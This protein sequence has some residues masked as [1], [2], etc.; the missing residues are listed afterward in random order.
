[1]RIRQALDSVQTNVMMADASN[2]VIYMNQAV[3]DMLRNA[4]TDI[5]EKLK[6]FDVDKILGGSIDVFH[7]NPAHQRSMLQAMNAVHEVDIKIGRRT[8]HLI[9]TPIYDNDK[10]RLGTAVE[11]QDMTDQLEREA[12]EAARLEEE[13]KVA[14]T[15]DRIRQALDSATGNMMIADA[16]FNI[17]YMNGAVEGM[18]RNAAND[19]RKELPH[20]D[21]N[22]LI[23][24]NMDIFHKDPSHQRSMMGNA[25]QPMIGNIK[26][27][28]RTMRVIGSPIK[29]ADTGERLGYAVEW[30]DRTQE[31]AI[32]QE[33]D[34][35]VQAAKAG[36]LTNRIETNDKEGFFKSLSAGVNELVDVADEVIQATSDV[37]GSLSRGDLS[38]KIRGDFQGTFG[39]LR[40]DV[41]NT[42]DML[43]QVMG[44]TGDAL[45]AMARGDLTHAI[46]GSYE[47]I[48]AQIVEDT[49]STVS[50]LTQVLD[51]INA[52]SA[53]VLHGAQEISEG[54]TNLSQRTEEQAA[55]LEETASS[56]EQMTSTVKA[57]AENAKRADELAAGA[58]E[59]ALR[60]GSVVEH[61]ITAMNAI[62]DSSRKIADIISVIDE[63]AFQTNLLALNAAVE[64]A[65]A[66]EQGR[67]FAVV[68]TEVR[69]LA[70][71]S[72]TAA[73]EI[74][75]LI[76]DS[77]KKVE[78]GSK[79]VDE[80]GQALTEIQESVGHVSNIIAEISAA[81]QEQSDGIE[82]VNTAVTQMDTMTQQ[83]AA[84]VEEAA[85]ASMSMG[86]QARTLSE[87]VG[88]FRTK[89]GEDGGFGNAL[90]S[91]GGGSPAKLTKKAPSRPA[92]APAG[93]GGGDTWEE[94]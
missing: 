46:E 87:L 12:A 55:N 74:K 39:Q 7:E 8:F 52:S 93:G 17:I 30:M 83:N 71:R 18:M 37:L 51:E 38:R 75:D 70:G 24:Q 68:A 6:S 9:A 50:K 41:N 11:W 64:A 59:Q 43:N 56:M 22:N 15:N 79:L 84:L 42:I 63:I 23:G 20:F 92:P 40:D 60:G 54:N 66:G 2:T 16:E 35:M 82:Q 91:S 44:Q 45:S 31:V 13:R 88:Y 65:R 32:E 89:S 61:A 36:N 78:E 62:T 47:G 10:E 53:Q 80:S 90:P 69:N 67:G 49:N 21:A 29:D 85:A 57:N 26:I 19:I 28:G 94:F 4:Q 34:N 33:I 73:K 5:R 72:A 77:V 27:G 58:K 25:N 81:S 14:A 3:T 1:M 48:Y 86:D 76:E